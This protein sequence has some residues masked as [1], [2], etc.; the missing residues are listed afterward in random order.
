MSTIKTIGSNSAT[1]VGLN[2]RRYSIRF[3]NVGKTFIY[4]QR[5]PLSGAY[6]SVS[7]SNF[8]VALAPLEDKNGTPETFETRSILAYQAVSGDC[9]DYCHDP[10]HNEEDDENTEDKKP[11]HKKCKGSLA[12][13]ETSKVYL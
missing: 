5:I 1:V 11:C 12:I 10:C 3:Q 9:Y 8:E 13:T 6:E 2:R 4:L 7:P